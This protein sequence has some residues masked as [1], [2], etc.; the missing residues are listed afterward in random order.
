MSGGAIVRPGVRAKFFRNRTKQLAEWQAHQDGSSGPASPIRQSEPPN[1]APAAPT[2]Q[3]A[4]LATDSIIQRAPVV[5]RYALRA[6]PL[7][8]GSP[9][10][11]PVMRFKL[12]KPG[13]LRSRKSR[14]QAKLKLRYIRGF[15]V[16]E[17]A[18]SGI[19]S[20]LEARPE[21][22][23]KKMSED[24]WNRLITQRIQRTIEDRY[25]PRKPRRK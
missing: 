24:Q 1:P 11:G 20:E 15:W 19:V 8:T 22:R 7:A 2:H 16:L 4:S 21:H 23:D 12:L 6:A 14:E 5:H 17:D 25:C 10:L 18:I 3:R 13:S 9:V